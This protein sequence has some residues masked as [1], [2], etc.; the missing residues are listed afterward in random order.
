MQKSNIFHILLF[1]CFLPVISFWLGAPSGRSCGFT[2]V[3]QSVNVPRDQY[4]FLIPI[5]VSQGMLTNVLM[6]N[7]EKWTQLGFS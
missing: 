5:D 7:A 4:P 3:C 2:F 1:F 6:K